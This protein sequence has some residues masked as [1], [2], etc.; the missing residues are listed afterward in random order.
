MTS[1][2]SKDGAFVVLRKDYVVKLAIILIV[3]GAALA[4][5]LDYGP[6][7]LLAL[8]GGG[9]L[10]LRPVPPACRPPRRSGRVRRPC[11]RARA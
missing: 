9:R 3:V 2:P 6:G 5:P 11:T 10:A 4:I 8:W 1:A 7:V